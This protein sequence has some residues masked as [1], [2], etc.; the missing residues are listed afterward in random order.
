MQAAQAAGERGRGGTAG[1]RR[2]ATHSAP[3]GHGTGQGREGAEVRCQ[4]SGGLIDR[5]D[6]ETKAPLEGTHAQRGTGHGP[7][8]G[9]ED[10]ANRS[11]KLR[12]D[13]KDQRE[14]GK[15]EE[16]EKTR[17]T[18]NRRKTEQISMTEIQRNAPKMKKK[19]LK[20]TVHLGKLIHSNQHQNVVR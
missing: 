19:G 20:N 1:C 4:G 16:V 5:G 3:W 7:S 9:R 13:E 6:L 15:W 2:A 18:H 10:K 17:H 11:K 8:G 14:G 12:N